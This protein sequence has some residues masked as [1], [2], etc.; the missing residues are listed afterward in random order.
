MNGPLRVGILGLG[1]IGA[2]L[3]RPDGPRTNTHLKACLGDQRFQIVMLSDLDKG[4]ARH[5]A[6]R[7][8]V[9]A[10]I[11]SADALL[12]AKLDV[13]VVATPDETHLCFARRAIEGGARAVIVEKPLGGSR[14]DRRDLAMT[15][16]EAG[17]LF[18]VNFSRRFLPNVANWM[19]R[20]HN[21]EYGRPL[22]AR[23]R[24][25]RGFRHNAI[26]GLDIVAASMPATVAS[27][28]R[29]GAVYE[30]YAASDP[31]FSLA[32]ELSVAGNPLPLFIE[33]ING[34]EQS[35][36]E[37][38]L[39]FERSR[40]TVYDEGGVRARFYGL[41]NIDPGFSPELRVIE[42]VDD[43]GRSLMSGL[44]TSVGSALL[45]GESFAPAGIDS[46]L[47]DDLADDLCAASGHTAS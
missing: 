44:W 47:A 19:G 39:T 29:I 21:G 34:R 26:H 30:D 35:T 32:A 11:T 17:A 42:E 40:M 16:Q 18:I 27:A 38:D 13:V 28:G 10:Q 43:T 36:F 23:V 45:D 31:T 12:G 37:V 9:D 1:R 25:G 6:E 3:D 46:I 41:F 5:E 14:S 4:T 7:F 2:G 8:K 15:A 33:G 20:A 24:Y 22:G